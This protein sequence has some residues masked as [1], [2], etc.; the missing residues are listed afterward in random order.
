MNNAFNALSDWLDF[1]E[2]LNPDTIELGLERVQRVRVAMQLN[3]AFPVITV[4]GTNGKGSVCAILESILAAA[5]YRVGCY[6]S[7][8]LVHYNERI[9]INGTAADDDV[10]VQAFNHVH[11]GSMQSDTVLTYFEFGT[12]AAMHVFESQQVDVAILEV[13]LGGRLDA[14]N[15]FDSDCAVLTNVALDHMDYL[16]TDREAIGTE[17]AGIFRAN[18]AA[19]CA[20][21]DMPDSVR[22]HASQIGAQ[23]MLIF[24]DYGYAPV[25]GHWDFWSPR[26]KRTAL[27]LPALRGGMQL[28][29]ASAALAALEAVK[30]RLPV[31]MQS[32]RRG[33]ISVSLA[34]RF[35]VLPP[36]QSVQ[37]TQKTRPTVILDVAHNPAAA[38]TL[39][40]NLHALKQWQPGGETVAVFA[41][42]RDKDISGVIA[43]L[44]DEIDSWLLAPIQTARGACA[45]DLRD[46][47]HKLKITRESYHIQEFG[48]IEAAFE[49]AC[50]RAGKNDRI[51]VAGSFHTVSVV[52]QYLERKN[53]Q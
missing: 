15:I 44:S 45:G 48:N 47:L 41:M 29:N 42:L 6:T 49:F 10:I 26:G 21:P 8:H 22:R 43:A 38:Q 23:L 25:E 12:L 20:D 46:H 27:P 34:G 17:K 7:P 31:D 37:T 24:Q 28:K 40:A 2:R 14:V 33:L 51:C 5:G 52:L 30:D 36:Q 11:Q 50:E 32:I 18:K 53:S 16:G 1:L 13:G 4:A 9:R 19:I 35:Q 39:A 3:P